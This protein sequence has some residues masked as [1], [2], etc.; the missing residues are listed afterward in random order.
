MDIGCAGGGIGDPVSVLSLND[1][2]AGIDTRRNDGGRAR[3]FFRADF[4]SADRQS[5][6]YAAIAW[7]RH[8]VRAAGRRS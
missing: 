5:P 1:L 4:I 6:D 3:R 7:Q 8:G 2:S